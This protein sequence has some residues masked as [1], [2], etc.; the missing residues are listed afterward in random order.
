MAN[1]YFCNLD[2][3]KTFFK[4]VLLMISFLKDN[5]NKKQTKKKYNTIIHLD[6]KA[7]YKYQLTFI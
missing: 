7:L 2:E 1:M 3:W 6:L 5:N 4:K